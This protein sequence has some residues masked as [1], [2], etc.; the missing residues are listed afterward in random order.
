MRFGVIRRFVVH[1]KG[2]EVDQH[3]QGKYQLLLP[4]NLR[5]LKEIQDCLFYIRRFIS[6]LSGGCQPFSKLMNQRRTFQMG[7]Q[8][9][10]E[11]D[12]IKTYLIMPPG[13]S[14]PIKGKPLVLYITS[15]EHSLRA[16]LA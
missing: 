4:K 5:E 1:H 15:L 12:D 2:V 10:M 6:N 16:L 8:C 7:E 3:N 14:S 9:Q 13:F 11:F